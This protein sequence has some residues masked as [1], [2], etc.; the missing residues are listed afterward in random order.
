M[1]WVEVLPSTSVSATKVGS[2]R[3]RGSVRRTSSRGD[4]AARTP[5]VA[6]G[7]R[8]VVPTADVDG[9]WGDVVR[10]RV[11]VAVRAVGRAV[12]VSV[13]DEA[14]GAEQRDDRDDDDEDQGRPVAFHGNPPGSLYHKMAIL[15]MGLG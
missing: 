5:A 11:V 13:G 3:G 7:G 8:G 14:A 10:R 2:G 6:T 9:S 12:A 15:S 1:T 4:T